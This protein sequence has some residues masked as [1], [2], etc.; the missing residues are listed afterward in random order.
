M[1]SQNK[2]KRNT[3]TSAK[4]RKALAIAVAEGQALD[5]PPKKPCR[6]RLLGKKKQVSLQP[7]P[8][9]TEEDE[10]G[11]VVLLED[12]TDTNFIDWTAELTW[13][14]VTAIEDDEEICDGLFPSVGAIKGKGGKPKTHHYYNLAV[15]CITEHGKYQDAFAM[16]PESTEAQLAAYRKLWSGRIKNRVAG[17]RENIAEMGETGARIKTEEEITPG[18]LLTTKWGPSVQHLRLHLRPE[19]R[20]PYLRTPSPSVPPRP[21]ARTGTCYAIKLGTIADHFGHVLL[22]NSD[23]D[24]YASAPAS[25]TS[26]LDPSSLM[27]APTPG[28]GAAQ[29]ELP[30]VHIPDLGSDPVTQLTAVEDS[31]ANIEGL[32]RRVLHNSQN[33]PAAAPVPAAP[34]PAVGP[35]F[36]SLTPTAKS[37]L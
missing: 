10:G 30:D 26:N 5:K 33:P 8:P 14:L 13:T 24:R 9:P 37:V 28:N 1:V 2:P 7:P 12:A 17:A 31:L 6:G 34:A 22:A 21:V 29:P 11:D 23:S 27:D 16:D 3:T 4:A 32:L 18:T 36:T 20:P 19:H 15:R 25:P 35:D